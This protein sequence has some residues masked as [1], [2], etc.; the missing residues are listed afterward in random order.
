MASTQ[1]QW[2]LGAIGENRKLM[3][4]FTLRSMDNDV[5]KYFAGT[6]TVREFKAARLKIE[7]L[8]AV[9]EKVYF[10]C[11]CQADFEGVLHGVQV[12]KVGFYGD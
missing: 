3:G 6:V 11:H 5:G 7:R 2:W 9:T 10:S 8:E 4:S 1:L 12:F